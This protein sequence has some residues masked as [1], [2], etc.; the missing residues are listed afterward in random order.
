MPDYTLPTTEEIN[1]Y[2]RNFYPEISGGNEQLTLSAELIN[3]VLT[4]FDLPP[5]AGAQ[6]FPNNTWTFSSTASPLETD[7]QVTETA[8]RTYEIYDKAKKAKKFG[9]KVYEKA[10]TFQEIGAELEKDESL[11]AYLK[12]HPE[13]IIEADGSRRLALYYLKYGRRGQLGRAMRARRTGRAMAR[14]QKA[15]AAGATAEVA[16]AEGAAAAA[17]TGLALAFSELILPF[18]IFT[19]TGRKISKKGIKIVF[20]I[21]IFSFLFWVLIFGTIFFVMQYQFNSPEGERNEI[22]VTKGSEVQATTPEGQLGIRKDVVANDPANPTSLTY[23]LTIFNNSQHEVTNI[24][25]EDSQKVLG[26]AEGCVNG[27]A[28]PAGETKTCSYTQAYA[29][30]DGVVFNNV[31]VTGTD[32]IDQVN[33]EGTDAASFG[34]GTS[35]GEAPCGYPIRGAFTQGCQTSHA[36]DIAMDLAAPTNTDVHSMLAGSAQRCTSGSGGSLTGYGYH[37]K[38][39]GGSWSTLHG[40]L[41]KT[42]T[43]GT[44]EYPSAPG[45]GT[46]CSASFPVT[47]N[48]TIGYVNNTGSSTGPHL[49]Y[50]IKKNGALVCPHPVGESRY[51][52]ETNKSFLDGTAS[53]CR[54]TAPICPPASGGGAIPL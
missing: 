46:N 28:L 13:L 39:S 1:T 35:T 4:H 14:A 52:Y 10:K 45:S 40:H 20:G 23:T 31:K 9:Q 17:G 19:K 51:F 44:P 3:E 49:H 7:S 18:L 5:D 12:A 48:Q 37:V 53:D 22:P 47:K 2:L 25:I 32:A 8:D 41:L 43:P 50:E 26:E 29:C 54:T 24:K 34:Q 21:L 27:F 42:I 38:V 16:A 11:V 36:P 30:T 15:R 6:L 33:L